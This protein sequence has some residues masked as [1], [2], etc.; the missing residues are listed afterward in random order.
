[1]NDLSKDI[2]KLVRNW[3]IDTGKKVTA[4][5]LKDAMDELGF[6]IMSVKKKENLLPCICGSK[7]RGHW[8]NPQF[9]FLVC[10]KCGLEAKGRTERE[11]RENWNKMIGEMKK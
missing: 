1:M 11:A 9:I 5:D 10:E 3:E 6:T 8:S 7:R 4:S 2:V